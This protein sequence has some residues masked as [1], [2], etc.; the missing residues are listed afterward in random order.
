MFHF[1]ASS[2]GRLTGYQKYYSF[3]EKKSFR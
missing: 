1:K 2:T 3:K